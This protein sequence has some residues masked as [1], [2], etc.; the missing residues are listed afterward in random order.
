MNENGTGWDR[1]FDSNSASMVLFARQ[2]TSI[3]SDAEDIVQEAFV[4]FWKNGF[5]RAHDPQAYLFTCVKRV[6]IE[7]QRTE[8]RRRKR[9]RI[10][11]QHPAGSNGQFVS[12]SELE[13]QRIGIETAL[14]ELSI[15]QREVL[16]LKIWG[17]LTFPQIS[18]ALEISPNTAASRYR[19]GLSHLRTLLESP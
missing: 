3:Q 14:D 11:A 8:F 18:Q 12:P 13:E 7:F 9:E 15:E 1:W 2:F 17:G 10:A 19:Y 5:D 16:V 6:A 4:R